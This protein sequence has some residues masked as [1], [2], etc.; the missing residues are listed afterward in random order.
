MYF[1]ADISNKVQFEKT[2]RLFPFSVCCRCP[3]IYRNVFCANLSL[4]VS[5]VGVQYLAVR[6]LSNELI[7]RKSSLK[8]KE[9]RTIVNTYIS[10]TGGKSTVES[11]VYIY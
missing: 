11:L 10:Y 2:H 5:T 6:T 7:V 1:S 3:D 9:E 8:S 4:V